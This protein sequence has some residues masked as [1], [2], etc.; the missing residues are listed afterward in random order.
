MKHTL[1]VIMLVL[2]PTAGEADTPESF[3]AFETHTLLGEEVSLN[4]YEGQVCLVV[5]VASKCGLTPQYK[6]LQ[7]LYAELGEEDFEILAFPSNDFMGQEPGSPEEI[8]AFCWTNYQVT[9]PIFEKVHVKGD[10]KHPIF[11]FLSAEHEEPSWNFTKYLIDRSGKV[12]HRFDP[13]T[14]PDDEKLRALIKETLAD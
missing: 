5:N 14:S 8:A 9:F 11:Q 4:Q 6:G 10:D 2:L 12:V 7:A 3:F 13:R 1:V